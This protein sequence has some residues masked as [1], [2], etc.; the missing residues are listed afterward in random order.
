MNGELNLV[1]RD[2]YYACHEKNDEKMLHLMDIFHAYWYLGNHCISNLFQRWCIHLLLDDI[3]MDWKGWERMLGLGKIVLCAYGMLLTISLPQKDLKTIHFIWRQ[4]DAP[5]S[6]SKPQS[7]NIF[8]S[9]KMV[10]CNYW[11]VFTWPT[12][13]SAMGKQ[14]QFS[15]ILFRSKV[16]VR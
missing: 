1:F 4:K 14:K 16:W 3:R 2:S 9:P 10:V 7:L 13:C 15:F 11:S 5:P 8:F 6:K 12:Y